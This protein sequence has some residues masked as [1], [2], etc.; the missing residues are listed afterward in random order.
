MLTSISKGEHWWRGTQGQRALQLSPNRVNSP[1]YWGQRVRRKIVV[2]TGGRSGP[3]QTL[4][5][6][7]S[8]CRRR[9]T[10]GDRLRRRTATSPQ[11]RQVPGQAFAGTFF[12]LPAKL[13]HKSKREDL[14]SSL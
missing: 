10:P 9:R 6:S 12:S 13:L 14:I 8:G 5:A 4:S 7:R 3:E 11:K 1:S 2:D